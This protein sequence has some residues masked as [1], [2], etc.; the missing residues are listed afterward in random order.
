MNPYE[1]VFHRLA[2]KPVD[3]APNLSIVMGFAA[4]HSGIPYKKYATDYRHLVEANLKCCEDFKIDMVSAISDP[5]REGHDMG[6]EIRV[7]ED[8]A[9]SFKGIFLEDYDDL[10]KLKVRDPLKGERMLD[11][12]KA[13]ELFQEKAGESYPVLGWIEGAFASASNLRG[14]NNLM[15][16][17]IERPAEVHNLLEI[18]AEQ[19]ILFAR[20]Q[21]R[22]GADFIG[23]GDAAASL[24][25]P[26]HYQEFVLP[27]EKRI[28]QAIQ[29][30]GARV[31]LHICGDISALLSQIARTGVDMVD[32]DWMVDFSEAVEVLRGKSAACG[33]F[34]PVDVLLQGSQADVRKAVQSCLA[35]GDKD[36]FIAPG[37]EVPGETS[38][39]NMQ[40]IARA[41]EE[42]S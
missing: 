10:A 21:V 5:C 22:A 15:L 24:I 14:V 20:E 19:A 42:L 23:M 41:L 40:E 28:S 17:L 3:R 18:C 6:A 39:A 30:A 35:A 2:G 1:R 26:D 31:K 34:D 16:D 33:N 9:P 32:I 36:T 12:I 29:E 11:R 27:Y 25:S 37:C 4:R 7:P 13:V 38:P 8:A